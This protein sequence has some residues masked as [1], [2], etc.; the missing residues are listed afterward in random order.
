M[1]PHMPVPLPGSITVEDEGDRRVLCLHGDLDA[2]VV[3]AFE[4]AQRAEAVVVDAIDAGAVNFISSRGIAVMLMTV[5]ASRGA[6]RAPML[7]AWSPPVDR[8]LRMSG[9]GDVFQRPG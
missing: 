7:R 9:I 2:A 4:S 6:A 8:L 5:E 1:E 3:V